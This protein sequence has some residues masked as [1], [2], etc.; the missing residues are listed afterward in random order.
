MG[1]LQKNVFFRARE[2]EASTFTQ[3]GTRM[4]TKPARARA[5]AM[6]AAVLLPC[7]RNQSHKQKGQVS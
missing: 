2:K 6:D 4:H 5:H 1:Y 3:N 7:P